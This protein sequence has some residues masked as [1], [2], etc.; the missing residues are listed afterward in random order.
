MAMPTSA[1]PSKVRSV[2]RLIKPQ[3]VGEALAMR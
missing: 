1:I 2:P 3:P